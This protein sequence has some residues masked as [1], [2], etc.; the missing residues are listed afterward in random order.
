MFCLGKYVFIVN[1][2]LY[3]EDDLKI[4]NG[5][6][7]VLPILIYSEDNLWSKATSMRKI[8]D[9]LEQD[10]EDDFQLQLLFDYFVVD[11][12][13]LDPKLLERDNLP[14]R[15]FRLEQVKDEKDL[16]ETIKDIAN[17]FRQ[18]DGHKE[19][20][21]ILCGWVKRVGLKRLKIDNKQFEAVHLL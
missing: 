7:L 17:R 20:A 14:S 16:I 11:V 2:V 10:S 1:K 21:N 3:N 4:S 13:R 15:L 19:L 9:P 6:T 12:G 8:H 18:E 5:S